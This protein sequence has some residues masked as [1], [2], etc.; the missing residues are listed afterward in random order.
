MRLNTP[1]LR[2]GSGGFRA[3]IFV[4]HSEGVQMYVERVKTEIEND[5]FKNEEIRRISSL[6]L[7]FRSFAKI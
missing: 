4:L 5:S 2:K 7:D 3:K 6:L 1:I